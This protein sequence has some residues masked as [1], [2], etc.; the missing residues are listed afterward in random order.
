MNHKKNVFLLTLLLFLGFMLQAQIDLI[1][2]QA[3]TAFLI[4]LLDDYEQ[5]PGDALLARGNLQGDCND[6]L[7]DQSEQDPELGHFDDGYLSDDFP[8]DQLSDLVLLCQ[9]YALMTDPSL[10]ALGFTLN[11]QSLSNPHTLAQLEDGII[12]GLNWWYQNVPY[13][14]PSARWWWN[15]IGK[16]RMLHQISVLFYDG[17]FEDPTV[18]P[19]PA[20]VPLSLTDPLTGADVTIQDLNGNNIMT[21]LDAIS[22]DFVTNIDDNSPTDPHTGANKADIAGS[23]IAK[24]LLE[25]DGS[26]ITT[27]KNYL[28]CVMAFATDNEPASQDFDGIREDYSFNQHNKQNQNGSN[29]FRRAFLYS[30]GYG[31]SFMHNVAV[32]GKALKGTTYDYLDGPK[33]NFF[34]Y[35]RYGYR[36]MLIGE[37]TDYSANGRDIAKRFPG[38]NA[39]ITDEDMA[40][41]VEMAVGYGAESDLMEMEMQ[42]GGIQTFGGKHHKH[43]W[44]SDYV[45]YQQGGYLSSLRMCSNRTL[46]TEEWSGDNTRAYWLPYGCTFIYKN[47]DEYI[48]NADENIF[49][50]WNWSFI[51]GVTCPTLSNDLLLPDTNDPPSTNN[52]F[53]NPNTQTEVFVGSASNDDYGVSAMSFNR[54]YPVNPA[55]PGAATGSVSAKKAWFHFGIEIIALGADIVGTTALHTTIN[56]CLLNDTQTT[57]VVE[58]DADGNAYWVDHG[59]IAYILPNGPEPGL[60]AGDQQGDWDNINNDC[61]NNCAVNG[62]V[63]RLWIDHETN[64]S[65]EPGSYEYIIVPGEDDASDYVR[66]NPITILQNTKF[67]QAVKKHNP[68]RDVVAGIVFYPNPDPNPGPTNGNFIST[69]VEIKNGLTL[70]TNHACAL[71]YDG[72]NEQICISSP[73]R[74]NDEIILTIASGGQTVDMTFSVPIDGSED[75]NTCLDISQIIATLSGKVETHCEVSDPEIENVEISPAGSLTSSNGRYLLASLPGASFTLDPEKTIDPLNGVSSYDLVHIARHILL[76]TPLGTAYKKIAADVNASGSI[77]TFDLVEIRKLILHIDS[78]FQNVDSWEFVDASHVFPSQ[79]NLFAFPSFPSSIQSIDVTI[80]GIT[81]SPNFTG[82]KMGDI[83]CNATNNLLPPPAPEIVIKIEDKTVVKDEIVRVPIRVANFTAIEAYQLGLKFNSEVLKKQSINPADLTGAAD[84]ENFG[85]TEMGIG[86]IRSVWLSNDAS[87]LN[88]TIMETSLPNNSTLFEL[89]FKA[90]MDYTRSSSAYKLSDLISL[91]D[92]VLANQGF[93]EKGIH[94]I[95]LKFVEEGYFEKVANSSLLLSPVKC[96]PN[97]AK[98][99]INFQLDLRADSD[100]QLQIF[101]PL[102]KLV[103]QQEM[104]LSAGV[105]V[106][107]IENIKGWEDGMYYYVIT[108][109]DD[110]ETGKFVKQ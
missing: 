43:F 22:A 6:L 55:D 50:F 85:L 46:G 65:T 87:D 33:T 7:E 74:M 105:Q 27:G 19:P 91:D 25:D 29:G 18:P 10:A 8:R 31:M 76:D 44:V 45:S 26:H 89:E 16:Q 37:M 108:V 77:T 90:K 98:S 75:P 69:P 60:Y 12:S 17:L 28:E 40:L 94:N 4:N 86:N 88:N 79:T 30:G 66:D 1:R 106:I 104:V 93:S 73:D 81:P 67:V 20:P 63:F 2:D 5:N 53:N 41:I 3:Q 56:Q 35:L 103:T 107:D 97:P 92:A 42:L 101:D 34:D 14:V 96:Y 83:N 59:D 11:D 57:P 72:L 38:S 61:N 110:V 95:R 9:A 71:L 80:N 21:I 84:P 109:G 52:P 39:R 36:W 13:Y 51:P 24:G 62:D 23:I 102:G 54:R 49:P 78:E 58:S 100:V 32:W 70:S 68:G 82:I 47:G 64:T 48:R 15:E 99:E